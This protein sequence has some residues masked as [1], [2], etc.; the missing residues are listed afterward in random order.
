RELLAQAIDVGVGEHLA[1][2]RER[3]AVAELLQRGLQHVDDRTEFI[4]VDFGRN[5]CRIT[6]QPRTLGCHAIS[7]N[8]ACGADAAPYGSVDWSIGTRGWQGGAAGDAGLV[9]SLRG[10]FSEPMRWRDSCRWCSWRC[11]CCA[12]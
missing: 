10:P 6:G 11:W 2:V 8:I 9:R 7:P 3:G 12:G 4:D 5:P 1:Q